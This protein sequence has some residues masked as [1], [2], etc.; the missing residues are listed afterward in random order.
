M[1]TM[2]QRCRRWFGIKELRIYR[3]TYPINKEKVV[4]RDSPQ[5]K[6][7]LY[8]S[9]ISIYAILDQRILNIL[10][11]RSYYELKGTYSSP[12][13]KLSFCKKS[14]CSNLLQV[15]LS[16]TPSVCPSVRRLVGWFVGRSVGWLVCPTRAGSFN[17]MHL[18]ENLLN[19]LALML[20]TSA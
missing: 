6:P 7:W 1:R 19:F 13:G 14:K 11:I 12:F 10:R 2:L 15:K 18:H 3:I 9:N 20:K 17:S 16:M 4:F 5:L 8:G